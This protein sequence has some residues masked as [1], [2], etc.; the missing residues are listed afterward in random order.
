MIN[1]HR[2]M[3]A[4]TFTDD[5]Y[6]RRPF[7]L[8]PISTHPEEELQ[9]MDENRRSESITFRL[10][11]PALPLSFPNI[12]QHK[13][14]WALRVVS[15]VIFFPLPLATHTPTCVGCFETR[16]R[17]STEKALQQL[18]WTVLYTRGEFQIAGVITSMRGGTHTMSRHR[19]SE[20]RT[21]KTPRHATQQ[22]RAQPANQ[23]HHSIR[24]AGKWVTP[25]EKKY[26]THNRLSGRNKKQQ[27]RAPAA[28]ASTRSTVVST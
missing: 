23:H 20:W 21:P 9:G 6:L 5:E 28:T 16:A 22:S 10:S 25:S 26:E 4:E 27:L 18:K 13:L 15:H 3:I 2:Q 14:R 12:P 7:C 19:G 11:L 17:P 1:R 24:V 8:S